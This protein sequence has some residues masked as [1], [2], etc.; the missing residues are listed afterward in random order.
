MVRQGSL[1]CAVS[2]PA[3]TSM[4]PLPTL[5]RSPRL[6]RMLA[7][8]AVV[9]VVFAMLAWY[10]ARLL[11]QTLLVQ[12]VSRLAQVDTLLTAAFLSGGDGEPQDHIESLAARLA[13]SKDFAYF[14]VF[15]KT[16][17]IV[18]RHGWNE[19]RPLPPEDRLDVL[20]SD[21]VL[22]HRHNLERE[23]I[24]AGSIRY[25]LSLDALFEART[26][27]LRHSALVIAAG[28]LA[29]IAT[30]LLFGGAMARELARVG[31]CA[32]QMAAG[33]LAVRLPTDAR[34]ELGELSRNLNTLAA[35]LEARL[36]ELRS[37][38]ERLALVI[39]GTSDGIFDWDIESGQRYYS[40]RY[41]ELVGYADEKTFRR[42]FS[43]DAALHPDDLDRVVAAR[44]DHLERHT[45]FDEEF[46][47]MCANGHYRW[48]HGRAHAVWNAAGKATRIAGSIA[49]IDARRTT[50]DALRES[51]ARFHHVVQGASEGIWDWDLKRR[52]YYISSGMKALL[53]YAESELPNERASFFHVMHPADLE[54]VRAEIAE[55]FTQRTPFDT[56]LRLRHRDGS[57][58]WY[59]ARG[60]A[61]WDE[62]GGVSRFAGACSSIL[63]QKQ[64]EERIRELLAEKQII[65]DNVHVG[66]VFVRNG[67][68][69]DI[70]RRMEELFGH[71]AAEL[72]GCSPATLFREPAD[73]LALEGEC[74]TRA[75]AGQAVSRAHELVRHDGTLFWGLVTCKLLDPAD[76]AQGAIWIFFDDSDH[77]HAIEALR[78]ERDFSDSLING[79][80]GVFYLVDRD[81]RFLRWN[82]NLEKVTGY[83]AASLSEMRAMELFAEQDRPTVQE[84]TYRTLKLGENQQELWLRSRDGRRIPFLMTGVRIEI[85]GMTHIV[86][87]GFD[88]TPRLMAE[89][90]V[91][92]LNEELEERVRERTTELA[93]ANKELES[94]SYSVSHDLSAPLRGID[95]FSRMLAE[96]FGALLPEV[97]RSYI[98]R[99]RA[100]TQRM[101]QL[102]DDLLRLSRVTRDELQRESLD[103]SH[104]ARELVDELRA[105]QAQRS[106]SI[107]IAPDLVV[108]A[109]R[110]LLRIAMS[111]LLRNA[112]KF[113][114]RR[115]A[116]TIQVGV[117]REGNETVYFVKDDGAG[118]DMRYAGRL[119]GAFHRLHRS[120]E[121]EGTGIGLAIVSRILHRHGGR[122]WAEAGI[123]RGA[124][125]FFTLGVGARNGH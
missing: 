42:N 34:G 39:Q 77:R 58:C 19:Q 45:P 111:N 53:G 12:M 114:S 72:V 26:T 89:E 107:E 27:M 61:V 85:D 78:N 13:G 101:Q 68:I 60:Q 88:I 54:R 33:D 38:E 28:M 65:I 29:S 11:D 15:D 43:E 83:H 20:P 87:I 59:R 64:A 47:F 41:R 92:H 8:V 109:D 9:L 37:N 69:A 123:D 25:G 44:R 36:A 99:I 96:D 120:S 93:A 63:V 18:A 50:E 97:G 67:A 22:D 24:H 32:R 51:E 125:F 30:L 116:A 82:R 4:R 81:G 62:S 80:P 84:A 102:I 75:G 31:A 70:N 35:N 56:E 49:D 14:V 5:A 1:I 79:M 110:N 3:A 95:G 98:T 55:H 71:P 2:F 17:K 106:V 118:F 105:A 119:F 108:F 113:T 122:I 91:R 57:V 115:S 6:R 21:K 94:F 66:I 74:G 124:T 48:F 100:A 16:G 46:R 121:F 76:P 10:S 52:R 40:P 23:G 7:P 117:L 104:M 86:G 73:F 112:W 90:Q 103:L